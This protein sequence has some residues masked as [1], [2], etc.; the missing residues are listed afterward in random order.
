[1]DGVEASEK[2]GSAA[3]LGS[4]ADRIDSPAYRRS[5]SP[6]LW[7]G[8][9]GALAPLLAPPAP[10]R[11]EPDRWLAF[12]HPALRKAARSLQ[13][14][15]AQFW[16]S[17]LADQFERPELAGLDRAL[18]DGALGRLEDFLCRWDVLET[19]HQLDAPDPSDRL[20]RLWRDAAQ[21]GD[22][23]SM[24]ERYCA[25]LEAAEPAACD[26]HRHLLICR[27]LLLAGHY[28][29]CLEAAKSAYKLAKAAGLPQPITADLCGLMFHLYD[30]RLKLSDFVTSD[31][32][33]TLRRA[34]KF[35]E[36]AI[37]VYARMRRDS[38]RRRLAV[39][40]MRLSFALDSWRACSG[41]HSW[42]TPSRPSARRSAS[43]RRVLAKRG[44]DRQLRLYKAALRLARMLFGDCHRLVGRLYIN[45][46]IAYEDKS[47]FLRAYMYFRR[48]A[49]VIQ[50]VYGPDHPKTCRAASVL[51][52]PRYRRAALY[53]RHLHSAEVGPEQEA[54]FSQRELQEDDDSA[55]AVDSGG[56]GNPLGSFFATSSVSQGA[57]AAS[58]DDFV[59][60][61]EDQLPSE[62]DE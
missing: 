60:L 55:G 18:D 44:S 19:F 23:S 26:L 37:G 47:C 16:L 11:T 5:W 1:K 21:C 38:G 59:L 22:Y 32:K 50:L 25:L 46:G 4:G 51:L 43:S 6:R 41:G 49:E 17:R 52:E 14:P 56:M 54:E 29:K 62:E 53:L 9:L 40:Q 35:A 48:W 36:A 30:D 27:V 34:I 24:A 7:A 8:V 3:G 58:E 57:A 42:L 31:Q 28:R 61:D 20:L 45:I 33:P 10:I 12:R 2:A 15:S 39:L 13:Q